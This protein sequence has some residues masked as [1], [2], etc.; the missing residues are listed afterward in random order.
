MLINDHREDT[1]LAVI[2]FMKDTI[3][4]RDVSILQTVFSWSISG[5]LTLHQICRASWLKYFIG[6]HPIIC[7]PSDTQ[8]FLFR[9]DCHWLSAKRV[10]AAPTVA[11]A[12]LCT[13]VISVKC[14]KNKTHRRSCGFS[15][16][17]PVKGVAGFC[18]RPGSTATTW[19]STSSGVHPKTR[20]ISPKVAGD[21]ASL[22]NWTEQFKSRRKNTFISSYLE[23]ISRFLSSFAIFQWILHPSLL[24]R[25]M[26]ILWWIWVFLVLM[27]LNES[28]W[29]T[30]LLR[31]K[32][33]SFMPRSWD[34]GQHL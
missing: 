31:H 13:D 11:P 19:S 18:E 2:L 1:A 29:I 28:W 5:H 33:C 3:N 26:S 4:K 14:L 32:N 15:E 6:C 9:S 17:V 10:F 25:F 20:I 16:T 24:S 34:P 8:H 7:W 12:F 27:Q 21:A 30:D 22:S 23:R